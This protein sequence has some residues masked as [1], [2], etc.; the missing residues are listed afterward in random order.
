MKPSTNHSIRIQG[1]RVKYRLVE[2]KS[3]RKL[4]IRIGPQGVEV[5]RPRTRLPTDVRAFLLAN[6][7][8]II[9]QLERVENFRHVRRPARSG[10]HVFLFR[11]ER[12]RIH[13]T[14]S[15][16]GG[17]NRVNLTANGMTVVRGKS[18][19]THPA[20]SVEYWLRQQARQE[21]LKQL[22]LITRRLKVSVGKVFVMEQQTKWGNCSAKG[23]LSFNWRLVL[24]PE[25]V[26]NYIVAHE[27]THLKVPNHSARFWLTLQSLCR[28]STVQSCGVILNRFV[29]LA[30]NRRILHG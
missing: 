12:T 10:L 8:W 26:L 13:I 20:K 6:Q 21:I 1:Q 3:A 5:I 2:S 16:A 22:G 25:F 14:K 11:G 30:N 17:P 18:S 4:R 24:A 23:N 15:T 27:A 28:V 29:A 7:N 19:K 9:D